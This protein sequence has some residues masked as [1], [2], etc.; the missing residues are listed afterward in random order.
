MTSETPSVFS[1]LSDAFHRVFRIGN[2]WSPRLLPFYK[3]LIPTVSFHLFRYIIS[4]SLQRIIKLSI[5]WID[6]RYHERRTARIIRSSPTSTTWNAGGDPKSLLQSSSSPPAAPPSLVEIYYPDLISSFTA[7][8]VTDIL[9][10]P[11]ETTLNRIHIQGTR[12]I[13]DN[14][15]TGRG[16]CSV[17]SRYEGFCECFSSI[18]EVEGLSGLYRGFG[19]LILQHCFKYATVRFIHLTLEFFSA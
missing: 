6:K 4:S 9:L 7:D 14:T 18:K 5:R 1:C 10:F 13:I 11:F 3:L 19:A 8:F 17:G 12:T 16:F 2:M 15:D